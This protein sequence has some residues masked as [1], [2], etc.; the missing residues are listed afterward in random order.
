MTLLQ[1]KGA[2]QFMKFCL[3]GLVN[4]A[5]NYSFFLALYRLFGVPYTA[6]AV[7][8]FMLGAFSG[9]FLNKNWTFRAHDLAVGRG[10]LMYL[11]AQV[12]S[13]GGHMSALLLCTE[14]LGVMPELSNLFG[15][16]VSTFINFS[17]SKFIVF[18]KRAQ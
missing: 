8:G 18:G 14:I 17:L 13:L 10:L 11:A 3:V 4:T 9:F 6:A 7:V 12:L 1:S 15:I 16:V 5:I 2:R